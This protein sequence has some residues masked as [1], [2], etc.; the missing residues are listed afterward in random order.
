LGASELSERAVEAQWRWI[1][2]PETGQLL[3]Y[4]NWNSGEPN[5]VNGGEDYL[6]TNLAALGRWN[7]HGGPGNAS[8][9]NGF[10]IEY[11]AAVPE[12]E[13]Y[14]M[15]LAGLLAVGAAVRRKKAA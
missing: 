4:F 5:D 10:V 7:D 13:A 2:G 1:S 15:L 3:T 12:P 9:Q 8:Q 11:A 6:Q 14:A